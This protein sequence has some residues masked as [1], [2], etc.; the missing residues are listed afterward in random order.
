MQNNNSFTLYS[1][2][3][4]WAFQ[5]FGAIG[6]LFWD[7]QWFT[8]ITPFTLLLY[9]LML[10]YDDWGNRKKLFLLVFIFL[11]GFASEVIGVNTGLIFGSY[12][13]GETLG[14][15]IANVPIVIGINWIVVTLICGTIAF[16]IKTPPYIKVFIAVS[17]MLFL[18]FLIE[19]VAPKIDMWNFE[20]DNSPAP[21]S[22]YI[23]WALVALPL[24][25][26]LI[27]NKLSFNFYLSLNLYISQIL[28]FAALSFI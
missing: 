1:V 7:R 26:Y 16:R 2:I 17:L 13:Y 15:Q 19:P 24:Q 28:F 3:V 9:F 23:T 25:W 14:L 11:W 27:Y 20:Y 12:Q 8:S 5:I 6:I 22:N 4:I 10:S 21:L 18:D